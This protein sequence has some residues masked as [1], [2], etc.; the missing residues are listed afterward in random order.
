MKMHLDS[1]RFKNITGEHIGS[2]TVQNPRDDRLTGDLA[3]TELRAINLDGA[4]RCREQVSGNGSPILSVVYTQGGLGIHREDWV[5]IFLT[6]P[7]ETPKR[8]PLLRT[9]CGTLA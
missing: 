2:M 8:A 1:G 4:G 7:T 5:S 9:S 3:D 6:P